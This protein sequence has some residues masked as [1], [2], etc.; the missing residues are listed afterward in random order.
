[1]ELYKP[2]HGDAYPS[3]DVGSKPYKMPKYIHMASNSR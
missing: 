3:I 1:M 2:P